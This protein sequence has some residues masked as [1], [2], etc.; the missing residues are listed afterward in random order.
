[1]LIIGIVAVLA[2]AGGFYFATKITNKPTPSI[3]NN[4]NQIQQVANNNKFTNEQQTAVI[5]TSTQNQ[6]SDWETYRNEEL[7]FEVGYP[8]ESGWIVKVES[9]G[10][11]VEIYNFDKGGFN[12]S[13]TTHYDP[14]LQRN[15]TAQEM[16]EATIKDRNLHQEGQQIIL[17]G[18]NATKLQY[19][20]GLQT[21]ITEIIAQKEGDSKVY[22]IDIENKPNDY[23]NWKLFDQI[24]STFK[25]IGKNQSGN[26]RPTISIISPAGGEVWRIGE[27]HT[28]KWKEN[29]FHG[30]SGLVYIELLKQNDAKKDYFLEHDDRN[31]I[32]ESNGI[33]SYA[34]TIPRSARTY[35]EGCG[36]APCPPNEV[37]TPGIYK[38]LLTTTGDVAE[39]EGGVSSL[40]SSD[41]FSIAAY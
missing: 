11:L 34:L 19:Y 10:A 8:N 41:L 30:K 7:G 4:Q 36:P 32:R 24:F 29:N 26:L 21:R 18:I 9:A 14:L 6:T 15:R 20:I 31:I 27:T 22:I 17:D 25:F 35:G 23:Q 1:M 33:S 12:V 3:T 13:Y 28:I 5:A 40:G 38:L 37:I 16:V 2:I 39:T